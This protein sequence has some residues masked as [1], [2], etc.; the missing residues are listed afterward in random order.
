VVGRR[1][2]G[3]IMRRRR[4]SGSC[5]RPLNFTVRSHFG[6]SGFAKSEDASS[7]DSPVTSAASDSIVWQASSISV[8]R[9]ACGGPRH[10]G[11][12][13]SGRTRTVV[14]CEGDF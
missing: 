10:L 8:A 14:L 7:F 12:Q 9:C 1:R 11:L 4:L 5:G 2:R 3:E 6:K 13:R